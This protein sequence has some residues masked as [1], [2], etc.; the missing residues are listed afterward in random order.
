M[1][2]DLSSTETAMAQE[3]LDA[4]K[5]SSA[6]EH[7]GGE[8]VAESMWADGWIQIGLGQVFIELSPDAA[9]AEALAGLVHEQGLLCG[10]IG[11]VVLLQLGEVFCY[12]FK[13][14]LAGRGQPL[15]PSFA[16]DVKDSLVKIDVGYVQAHQLTDADPG[17]VDDLE[18]SQ[19]AQA[20]EGASIRCAEKGLDLVLLEE[21]GQTFFLL[22]SADDSNRAGL[23]ISPADQKF[24]E[25]SQGSQFSGGSGP[26]IVFVV[27]DYEKFANGRGGHC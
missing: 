5:V 1:S 16:P 11:S 21:L 22:G 19:V 23:Q 13:G 17:G 3:L 26:G 18:H 12:S 27:E 8:G 7:M 25:R 6:I 4:A 10:F 2:I 9:S 15:L 20:Q 14:S 24:I